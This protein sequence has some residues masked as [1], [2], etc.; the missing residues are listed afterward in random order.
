[1]ACQ[2]DIK[3]GG[4]DLRSLDGSELLLGTD[5]M[6]NQGRRYGLIGR[7]GAGKSTLLREIAYYKFEKFPKNLK[8]FFNLSA[9]RIYMNIKKNLTSFILFRSFGNGFWAT[10]GLETESKA[11]VSEK[12]LARH[13]VDRPAAGLDGGT[14]GRG[15]RPQA[16][17]LGAAQRRRAPAASGGAEEAARL[18][19]A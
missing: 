10:F 8:A 4:I 1:M 3:L 5:L 7:N 17:G 14:G 6:L 9:K 13:R 16:R 2:A 11:F 15:R 19:E 18:G 12:N